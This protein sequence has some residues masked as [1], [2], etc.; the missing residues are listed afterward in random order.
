MSHNKTTWRMSRQVKE[1]IF[2]RGLLHLDTPTHF[3]GSEAEGATDMPLLYDAKDGHSPL[4]TGASI[5]GALRNYLREYEKGYSWAEKVAEPQKSWAEQLFGHLHEEANPQDL[6]RPKR[7]SVQ[8][9]LMIDDALGTVPVLGDAVEVRDGVAIEGK[10]RT[11]KKDAKFD[12]ELLAAGTVFPMNFELWVSK[13]NPQ[14]LE[15]LAIALHGLESGE[16]GLGKRKRRGY[17]RC[18]VTG[19]QVW[20]YR[21]DD[22]EQLLGWLTH[23]DKQATN[24][25]KGIY[26]L[27]GVQ[28][29]STHQ[30]NW[31]KLHATFA[32]QGSLF[33]RSYGTGKNDPDA[34]YQS[35]WRDGVAKPVLPGTSL[36]GVLRARGLR[37]AQTVGNEE[38][39]KSLINS[40]FG[41]ER[42]DEAGNEFLQASRLTVEE[43][44]IKPETAVTDLVQNRVSID[45]FTG[46]A[47]D[48]ALFNQQPLFAKDETVVTVDLHLQNPEDYDVGLLLLLL[49]DLWT[50]DLPLG[51]ESSVGR[52]RLQGR[53]AAL[54]HQN[55]AK[56]EW[57]LTTTAVSP[58][59]LT[60]AT[61]NPDDLQTFVTALHTHLTGEQS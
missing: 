39:A 1:R 48:T 58:N 55:G 54:T 25:Q 5:A 41:G 56:R 46:G 59:K 29:T 57:V 3:G 40:L 53:R 52:G 30:G 16:I 6:Q 61:G 18:H 26:S 28:P 27:L 20:R 31:F 35:S 10:T 15:S 8:S 21:M 14:L 11:A 60:F 19:W 43:T 42:K 37:I 9:W 33:I 47:R 36:A 7:S 50:E 2:I 13:D 24:Y 51:G 17:G 34:A 49:K 45:R 38:K 44:V 32:L 4:L 12:L 23:H 22:V